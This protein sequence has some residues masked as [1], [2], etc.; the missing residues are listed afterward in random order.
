[1]TDRQR[2]ALLRSA[3]ADLKRTGQGYIQWSAGGKTGGYWKSAVAKLGTLEDDLEPPK[4]PQLG[5]LWRGGRAVL[6]QAPTHNTDGIPLYPAIDDGWVAGREILAVEDM[7]VIAPYTS[8]NPGAA[9]YAK[10]KSLIRYW[11]GHLD[12]SHAV[13]KRF[14]KGQVVGRVAYGSSPH[15]HLGINIELLVGA[16][17][18]LKYG[19]NGNGPDYTYGSPTIGT[20]LA[21][22]L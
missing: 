7:T 17:R 4:V 13:G 16:G 19:A 21:A 5:P 6:N 9:F 2:L 14:V 15:A 8:A 20:Q 18:Q 12:R 3:V 1:M 11:Y 22:L 10:G